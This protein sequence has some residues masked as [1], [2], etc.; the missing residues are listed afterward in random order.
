MSEFQLFCYAE[1]CW[2]E[3]EDSYQQKPYRVFNTQVTEEEYRRIKSPNIKLVFDTGESYKT[4]YKTSFKKAWSELAEEEKQEF[5][6][7]PHFNWEIFT[8][9][10]WVEPEEK[11]TLEERVRI[12][13]KLL[14]N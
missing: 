10:T 12:L 2:R 11:K 7:I 9:I 5:F 6:D 1:E 4:R 8:K 13:E 14:D 3:F